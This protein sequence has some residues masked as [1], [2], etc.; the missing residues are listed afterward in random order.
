MSI[1]IARHENEIHYYGEI[2]HTNV[3]VSPSALAHIYTGVY[4]A[5]RGWKYALAQLAIGHDPDANISHYYGELCAA[6]ID[7]SYLPVE[8]NTRFF[9]TGEFRG[10]RGHIEWM[11]GRAG[12]IV[13]RTSDGPRWILKSESVDP[14]DELLF[15]DLI[16]FMR[17]MPT[18]QTLHPFH[19]PQPQ[20][21]QCG[22][23]MIYK[24]RMGDEICTI[25]SADQS[26]HFWMVSFPD[27]SGIVSIDRKYLRLAPPQ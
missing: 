6:K 17:T 27:E 16:D 21:I 4:D 11:V 9:Y 18:G 14:E 8:L 20:P 3:L 26:Q 23:T 13:F 22:T 24:G 5:E 12:K 7:L 1:P 25:V 10:T 19:A 15:D 2:L